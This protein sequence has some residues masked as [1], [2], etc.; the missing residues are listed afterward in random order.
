MLYIDG[1]K[2]TGGKTNHELVFYND[3]KSWQALVKRCHDL[4]HADKLQREAETSR[5]SE[6]FWSKHVAPDHVP[7][8]E[9]ELSR[10]MQDE[11]TKSGFGRR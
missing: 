5:Q 6:N 8:N 10:S 2:E 9:Q 4:T 1:M 3:A 11:I 7:L